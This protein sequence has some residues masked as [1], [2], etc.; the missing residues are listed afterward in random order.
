MAAQSTLR[1]SPADRFSEAFDHFYARL[2]ARLDA[3]PR[4]GPLTSRTTRLI[5]TLALSLAIVT[6]GYGGYKTYKRRKAERETGQAIRH[7]PTRAA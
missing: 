2:A 3:L 7:L 6:G 5:A 1:K 4:K